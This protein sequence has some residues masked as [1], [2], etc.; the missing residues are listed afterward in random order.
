[1]PN[2]PLDTELTAAEREAEQQAAAA[3]AAQAA[4]APTKAYNA[5]LNAIDEAATVEGTLARDVEAYRT[6]ADGFR[7][8]TDIAA[9]NRARTFAVAFLVFCLVPVDAL[10]AL[11]GISRQVLEWILGIFSAD[12][13]G[14]ETIA[15]SWVV[16]TALVLS[17]ALWAVTLGIK[18]G[19][20]TSRQKARLQHSTSTLE[21]RRLRAKVI[22][23][24][25]GRAAYLIVFGLLLWTVHAD[26]RRRIDWMRDTVKAMQEQT[27]NDQRI[28]ST[29]LGA[30][31]EAPPAPGAPASP[32]AAAAGVGVGVG[33]GAEAFVL[34]LLFSLHAVIL[35]VIPGFTP[36]N[37]FAPK[38]FNL[39]AAEARL[40]QSQMV[41]S[42]MLRDLWDQLNDMPDD[43]RRRRVD[44]MPIRIA[45]MLNREFGQD[46]IVTPGAAAQ[47]QTG[48]AVATQVG[49][50]AN[51]PAVPAPAP[52]PDPTVAA[53]PAPPPPASG[54]ADD[55]DPAAASLVGVL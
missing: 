32:A 55:E 40:T 31:T 42:R 29:M 16:S 7:T 53:A 25:A 34:M 20:S 5:S 15:T 6:D 11:S 50:A 2:E 1:M 24:N 48:A 18:A 14:P 12:G 36:V 37:P 33:M 13:R 39:R 35:C 22:W 23:K 47:P 51:A 10:L 52:T 41:K 46:V 30:G 26:A 54:P 27:A 21:I 44:A 4:R 28:L 38:P 3:A 45:R 19:T 43:Q 17:L 8:A 49:G 9:R